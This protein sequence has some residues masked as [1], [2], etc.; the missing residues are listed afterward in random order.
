M[1]GVIQEEIDNAIVKGLRE[2]MITGKPPKNT[3]VYPMKITDKETLWSKWR[4]E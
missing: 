3:V 4:E 1:H 2:T